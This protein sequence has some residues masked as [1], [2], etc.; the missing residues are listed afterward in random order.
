M[1][2]ARYTGF[3][4]DSLS[5]YT[6]QPYYFNRGASGNIYGPIPWQD[7]QLLA[8]KEVKFAED[9]VT[10]RLQKEIKVKRDILASIEHKHLIRIHSFD[11]SQL[12]RV[13]FIV[14]EFAA[15]GSLRKTLSSLG[16]ENRLPINVVTDWSKQIAEGMLYLHEKNIVHRDLKSSNSECFQLLFFNQVIKIYY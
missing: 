1:A 11:I 2:L 16:S 9:K 14:M 8:I 4:L 12:P 13:M 7:K 3:D 10:D 15:G 6:T 5:K